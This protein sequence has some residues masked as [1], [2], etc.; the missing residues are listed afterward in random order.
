MEVND[1]VPTGSDGGNPFNFWNLSWNDSWTYRR[2]LAAPGDQNCP[3]IGDVSNQNLDNDNPLGYIFLSAEDA[4]L[5][6]KRESGWTGGLNLTTLAATEQRSYG[7]YHYV[8]SE[9]LDLEV[10][11]YL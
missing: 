10:R 11:N 7:Y 9:Q 6:A 3:N 5:Q 4:K 8:I 2:A 1:T